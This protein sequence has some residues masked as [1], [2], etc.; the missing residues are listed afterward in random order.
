MIN[1]SPAHSFQYSGSR[2]LEQE[3]IPKTYKTFI[4]KT[5]KNVHQKAGIAALGDRVAEIFIKLK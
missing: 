3:S 2:S 1:L 5:L 4:I